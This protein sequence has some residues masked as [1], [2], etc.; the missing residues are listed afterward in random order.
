M[1]LAIIEQAIN[2]VAN[3]RA[4]IGAVQANML[5]TNINNLGSMFI[6]TELLSVTAD[7]GIS[8]RTIYST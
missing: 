2:D 3:T 6:M 1:A 4:Q 7:H 5:Q 8:K